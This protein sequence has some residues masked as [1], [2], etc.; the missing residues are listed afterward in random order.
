MTRIIFW[1]LAFFGFCVGFVAFSFYEGTRAGGQAVYDLL[2][3]R[4]EE[5]NVKKQR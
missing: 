4:L 2:H 1:S 5:Y 3:K